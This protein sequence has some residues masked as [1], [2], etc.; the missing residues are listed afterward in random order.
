M[1]ARGAGAA[2]ALDGWRAGKPFS[3]VDER[4]RAG[5]DVAGEASAEGP[6][7]CIGCSDGDVTF[8]KTLKKRTVWMTPRCS[9]NL[10]GG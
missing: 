3:V 2:W 6:A 1:P 10:E 9:M 5:G 4:P 7:S 8:M